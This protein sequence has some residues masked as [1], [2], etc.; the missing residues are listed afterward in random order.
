M[1]FVQV[2]LLFQVKEW[3]ENPKSIRPN[4]LMKERKEE[5]LLKANGDPP[6][7]S[8]CLMMQ[9]KSPIRSQGQ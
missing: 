1:L 2:R 5:L 7:F 8:D 3:P 9:L 6:F 4:S